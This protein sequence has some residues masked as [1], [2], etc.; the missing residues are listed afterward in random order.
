[1]G[2][3]VSKLP[4]SKPLQASPKSPWRSLNGDRRVA[5][6]V[7]L[8]AEQKEARALYIQRLISRG[9]GFRAST[10]VGWPA[11][12]LA[13]EVVRLNA[14]NADDEVE[15]MQA[16]Y[17]DLEPAIQEQFLEAAG[18]KHEGAVIAE[19]VE[20]PYCDAESVARAAAAILA[21]HGEAAEHYL[22]TIARYNPEGWPGVDDVVA[23]LPAT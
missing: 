21:A 14:P 7:R 19:G 17:V 2:G 8:F 3:R 23:G 10:L 22:R 16:L 13:R 9:G 12:K 20:A 15:L 11:E 18:V 4:P 5:I 1:M 6:L